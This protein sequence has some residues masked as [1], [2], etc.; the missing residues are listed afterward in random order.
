VLG[1]LFFGWAG[2]R[3]N[4][5]GLL[6][7]I[8]LLRSVTLAVYFS[9]PPTVSSTLMF[10]AAMGFLWFGVAPLMT[11]AV[12][13]MFGLK[14]QAM[15]GGL[16]FMVHQFGSFLGAYGGGVLYDRLGS[17]TLAWQLAVGIGI[18]AG[19]VQMMFAFT[20][21][22][23]VDPLDNL[24]AGWE[25]GAN[26]IAEKLVDVEYNSANKWERVAPRTKF[27]VGTN[28]DY[29]LVS[30]G[31]RVSHYQ[32]V[33]DVD[34]DG[35]FIGT[36]PSDHNQIKAVVHSAQQRGRRPR[37]RRTERFGDGGS[38]SR[39]GESPCAA[40]QLSHQPHSNRPPCKISTSPTK[41]ARRRR[42]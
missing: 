20:R 2:G 39:F 5:Q 11:G 13:E 35:R 14:W 33:V 38:L 23:M 42:T 26:A 3:W 16:A 9:S 10:A 15:I 25:A 21:G 30:K 29:V 37:A 12:V 28:V 34:S 8:Y 4:K 6:G 41:P 22:G 17:Y 19:V 36:I 24:R 1:S 7:L 27:D 32:T 40:L 31:V 18:T